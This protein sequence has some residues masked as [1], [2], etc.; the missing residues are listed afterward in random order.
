MF[1]ELRASEKSESIKTVTKNKVIERVSREIRQY[2]L[3]DHIKP[4][5]SKAKELFDEFSQRYWS[6]TLVLRYTL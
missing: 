6:L 3:E 5:W 2:S 4:S 1:N